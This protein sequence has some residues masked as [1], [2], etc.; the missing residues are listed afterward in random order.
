MGAD[1]VELRGL[2]PLELAQALDAIA[3]AKGLDRNSYVVHVLSFEVRRY[4]PEAN[5]AL[6]A[7]RGNPLLAECEGSP[8]V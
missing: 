2:C 1:K 4:L 6:R 5:V 7:L 3:M 8:S